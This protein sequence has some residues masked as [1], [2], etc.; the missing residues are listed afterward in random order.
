M[1]GWERFLGLGIRSEY[2]I[3]ILSLMR[4][5]GIIVDKGLGKKAEPVRGEYIASISICLFWKGYSPV[6]R[7]AIHLF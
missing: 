2:P 7:G 1:L 5:V 4:F 6:M 3:L